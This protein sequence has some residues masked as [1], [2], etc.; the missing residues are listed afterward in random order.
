[1]FRGHQTRIGDTQRLEEQEKSFYAIWGGSCSRGG[2][3]GWTS[4]FS[5]WSLK[6]YETVLGWMGLGI[7]PIWMRFWFK[8][9]IR[10]RLWLGSNILELDSDLS[11]F[12]VTIYT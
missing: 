9:K 8:L 4:T 2:I 6:D 3:D 11:K 12:E 5:R 10:N 1:M 7:N